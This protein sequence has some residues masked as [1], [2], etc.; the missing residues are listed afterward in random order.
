MIHRNNV[1]LADF[2]LIE[3]IREVKSNL[4][5]FNPYV[6]YVDP[7]KYDTRNYNKIKDDVKFQK[8]GDIYSIGVLLWE[9]S[10]GYP[11]F[12]NEPYD[13]ALI[14]EIYNGRRETP[15]SNTSNEYKLLYTGKY[16]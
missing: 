4:L 1:K 11:P 3:R 13:T 6:P 14:L 5:E 10:S 9:I 2:G 12:H 16:C 15:V 7:I 8:T